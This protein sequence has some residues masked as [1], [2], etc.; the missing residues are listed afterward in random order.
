M[1]EPVVGI[2]LGTTYS[3]VA[4][5]VDGRP[6]II[7]SRNGGRLTP[8]MVGFTPDG[9]RV[10]GE[11]ARLLAEEHPAL[12]AYATKRFIGRRYSPELALDARSIVPFNIVGGSS[13]EIRVSLGGNELPLTQVGAMILG[14]LKLDAESYFGKPVKK[15]VIT[16]P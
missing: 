12:V 11:A 3:A 16:V 9:K 6:V 10:I 15:C 7:P 4:A 2:D 1:R 14:E 13:G 8:S 5:I